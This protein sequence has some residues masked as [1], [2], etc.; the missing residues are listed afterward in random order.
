M[1]HQNR[2]LKLAHE[3]RQMIAHDFSKFEPNRWYATINALILETHATIIDEIIELHDRIVGTL[4]NRSKCNQEKYFQKSG[5]SINEKLRLYCRI[6]NA[7][8]EAMQKGSNPFAGLKVWY[9]GMHLRKVWL[10]HKSL[11]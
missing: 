1:I 2:L 6:G 3:G 10:I 9:H 7:L 8:I 5:K 4:F 11:H